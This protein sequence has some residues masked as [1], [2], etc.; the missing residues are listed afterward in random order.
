MSSSTVPMPLPA[1]SAAALSPGHLLRALRDEHAVLED[2]VATLERQRG[3]VSRDDIE[4]V[5]D[6]ASRRIG[7]SGPIARRAASVAAW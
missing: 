4:A 6:S 7:S 1:G 3:A 5:N 2:L